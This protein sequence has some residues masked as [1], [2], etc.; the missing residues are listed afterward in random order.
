[1][2]P[3]KKSSF[4]EFTN[5]LGEKRDAFLKSS[6]V[7]DTKQLFSDGG[8]LVY[9]DKNKKFDVAGVKDGDKWKKLGEDVTA[10]YNDAEP[11]AEAGLKKTG[12]FL[13]DN[14]TGIFGLLGALAIGAFTGMDFLPMLLIAAVGFFAG[15]ALGDGEKGLFGGMFKKEEKPAAGKGP[16]VAPEGPAAAQEQNASP[17]TPEAQKSAAPETQELQQKIAA[18]KFA[19]NDYL[20]GGHG[21]RS[22]TEMRDFM[23]NLET[24]AKNFAE[25]N[26]SA[27][28]VKSALDTAIKK[29]EWLEKGPFEGTIK[30]K[31]WSASKEAAVHH[32]KDL[33]E[34]LKELRSLLDGPAQGKNIEEKSGGKGETA[35]TPTAP[36]QTVNLRVSG[37]RGF[38]HPAQT[39]YFNDKNERVSQK[40][41]A[42]AVKGYFS[43]E[44]PFSSIS[45]SHFTITEAGA[46]DASGNIALKKL[47]NENVLFTKGTLDLTNKETISILQKARD[48]VETTAD[49][50]LTFQKN[51]EP[52]KDPKILATLARDSGVKA[53]QGSNPRE[54]SQELKSPLGT[55]DA[56]GKQHTV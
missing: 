1:M 18:L 12:D 46:P 35:E 21:M 56:V 43:E 53:I 51:G 34:N 6:F 33:A 24:S 2:A 10:M 29:A 4:D 14:K 3:P 38:N 44:N 40:D 32:A 49:S 28:D 9:D 47:P 17:Q 8:S 20:N 16:A 36:E 55:E 42:F 54:A 19:H 37:T 27:E 23:N 15:G 11:T 30:G 39:Y 31:T 45:S 52:N 22:H 50:A 26:G 13:K 5:S 41:A 48:T 25:G 7:K